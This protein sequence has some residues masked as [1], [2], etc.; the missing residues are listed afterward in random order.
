MLLEEKRKISDVSEFSILT[1]TQNRKLGN[2]GKFS[3]SSNF[4]SSCNL[5][6]KNNKK[7]RQNLKGQDML[8]EEKKKI[9]E[10]SEFSILPYTQNRKLGNLRKFSF[11][12]NFDSSCNLSCKNNKKVRQNLKGQDML[13]EEKRKISEVS[14]FLILPYTQNR[15]LG[16][17]GKFSFTLNLE[18]SCNLRCKN[19]KKIS[20][21]KSSRSRYASIRKKEKSRGLQVFD[22]ALYPKSKT[23]KSRKVFFHFEFW[24][25]L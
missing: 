10:V 7:V 12:S 17:L 4:D 1:Y 11:S 13:L 20:E 24:Q 18:S 15:K 25:K 8:L 22:F 23:R 5:R 19:N 9:S 2:L 16:N 3:F 6:C 14:E 21:T